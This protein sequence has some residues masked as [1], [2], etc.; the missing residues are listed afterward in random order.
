MSA[1][2]VQPP[3]QSH[4]GASNTAADSHLLMDQFMPRYDLA[5]VHADV[6]RAPPAEC[7]R[8]ASEL[9]LFQTPVVRTLLG[10]RGLPQR[11][12]VTLTGRDGSTPDEA[13]PRTFRLKDLVGLGW[14][15]LGETPGKEMVLGQV[16]RPWKAVAASTDAPTT[17]EQ[18][19]SFDTPGFAKI[20]AGLGI[21]PY[22]V[23]WSIVRIE[24]RVAL[25]D[26][27]SSRRF[28]RYWLLIGPF[29]ALIRRMALRL[30]ATELRRS[31]PGTPHDGLAKT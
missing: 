21:D 19:T 27:N 7:Y 11:V 6:F 28:R 16:S 3:G 24:T 1:A 5:V 17:P 18:F 15:L 29:S 9:D 10:I 8:A 30:L 26:D 22:R 14:V 20:A 23:D 4:D 13:S 12:V 2:P 25:T 31:A